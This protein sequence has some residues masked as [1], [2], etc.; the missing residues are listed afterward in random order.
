MLTGTTIFF[1][2]ALFLLFSVA[3]LRRAVQNQSDHKN[4]KQNLRD[5]YPESW[6]ELD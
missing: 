5:S 4:D 2:S 6:T 3:K 1:L